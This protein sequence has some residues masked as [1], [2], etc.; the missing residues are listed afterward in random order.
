MRNVQPSGGNIRCHQNTAFHLAKIGDNPFSFGL[1]QIAVNGVGRLI[2]FVEFGSQ[3]FR[4]EFG[5]N[6]N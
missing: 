6:K 2:F 3:S 1:S 4:P 5:L